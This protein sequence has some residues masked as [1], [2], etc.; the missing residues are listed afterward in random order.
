MKLQISKHEWKYEFARRLKGRMDELGLTGAELAERSGISQGHISGML[1][2][3][4]SPQ[5]YTIYRIAEGLSV[6]PS[7]L[8][9]LQKLER[10]L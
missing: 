5:G 4:F 6:E 2:G 8:V 3:K 10:L 7:Y 1:N 9:D